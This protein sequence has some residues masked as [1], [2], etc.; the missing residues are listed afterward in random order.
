MNAEDGDM[1]RWAKKM[2]DDIMKAQTTLTAAINKM[3]EKVANLE[4]DV[5]KLQTSIRLAYSRG[6]PGMGQVA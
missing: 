5:G 1:P 4:I 2:H 3:S 6:H